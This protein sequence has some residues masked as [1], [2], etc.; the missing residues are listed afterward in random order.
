MFWC[1]SIFFAIFLRS[2]FILSIV[3]SVCSRFF[4][5]FVGPGPF[6]KFCRCYCKFIVCRLK[7]L[8]GVA[9]HCLQTVFIYVC[10][11]GGVFTVES[12]EIGPDKRLL[13][14]F[15]SIIYNIVLFRISTKKECTTK[16]IVFFLNIKLGR[17]ESQ[18]HIVIKNFV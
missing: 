15:K 3:L 6:F 10:Y 11:R 2:N 1:I 16:I 5:L 7:G 17:C 18:S 8:E 4:F 13:L 9:L 14:K 12:T